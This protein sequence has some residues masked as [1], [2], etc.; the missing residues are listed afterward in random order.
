[1]NNMSV[2]WTIRVTET[3][4]CTVQL[5]QL[6]AILG[7]VLL[8]LHGVVKGLM[9]LKSDAVCPCKSGSLLQCAQQTQLPATWNYE[10]IT[11]NL[12]IELSLTNIKS[13]PCLSELAP[14]IKQELPR[15]QDPRAEARA[16]VNNVALYE[17]Q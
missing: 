13:D 2:P 10:A 3:S 15:S 17:I 8:H 5:R 4:Q 1:M 9:L 11:C 14:K 12:F 16:Q 6:R 7:K